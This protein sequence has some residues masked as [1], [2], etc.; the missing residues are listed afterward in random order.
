MDNRLNRLK[1]LQGFTKKEKEIYKYVLE[2]FNKFTERS[3][4]YHYD[5]E[6]DFDFVKPTDDAVLQDASEKF[7]LPVEEIDRIIRSIESKIFK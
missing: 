6:I 7:G 1:S 2:K 4:F 3:E 5:R